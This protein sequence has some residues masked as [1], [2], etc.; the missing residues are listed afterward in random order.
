MP[1]QVPGPDLIW[2]C[3]PLRL[4]GLCVSIK[5]VVYSCKRRARRDAAQPLAATKWGATT[6]M[7]QD[8]ANPIRHN[9]CR[10]GP[11]S[12]TACSWDGR[13]EPVAHQNAVS[14]V[15]GARRAVKDSM[16]VLDPGSR[17]LVGRGSANE[18]AAIMPHDS[19]WPTLQMSCRTGLSRSRWSL[20]SLPREQDFRR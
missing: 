20:N 1:S 5:T 16:R 10:V 2:L 14:L 11:A 17:F 7:K 4:C 8:A 13:A 3:G 15:R 9:P 12:H 18:I 19:P 6:P